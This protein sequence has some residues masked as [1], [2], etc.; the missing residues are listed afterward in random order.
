MFEDLS[1]DPPTYMQRRNMPSYPDFNGWFSGRE[2]QQR[3]QGALD[4][5]KK[6]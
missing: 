4:Q 3:L 6:C 1:G 5:Q 2:L